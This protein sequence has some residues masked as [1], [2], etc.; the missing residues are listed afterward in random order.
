MALYHRAVFSPNR[1]KVVSPGGDRRPML[2]QAGVRTF[3]TLTE[4]QLRRKMDEFN[5]LFIKVSMAVTYVGCMCKNECELFVQPTVSPKPSRTGGGAATGG[6][7]LWNPAARARILLNA[8]Q[9][10]L[11][12]CELQVHFPGETQ[13]AEERN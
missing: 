1:A 11:L 12:S 3:A 13:L 10:Y 8:V 2:V 4:E 9:V 7:I 6:H 5:D